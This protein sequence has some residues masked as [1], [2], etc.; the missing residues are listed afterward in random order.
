MSDD[1]FKIRLLKVLE[2]AGAESLD[3]LV[4]WIRQEV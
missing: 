1:D 2:D 3:D 4:K